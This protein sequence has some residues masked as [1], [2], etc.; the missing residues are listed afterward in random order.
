MGPRLPMVLGGL[1]FTL[2]VVLLS[3][4]FVHSNPVYFS[5]VFFGLAFLG[6]GLGLFTTP[7]TSVAVGDAPVEKAA[8]AGGIFKMGSSLGGAFGITIHMTVFGRCWPTAA[9]STPPPR[10]ASGSASSRPWPA[11]RCPSPWSPAASRT[12]RS[13]GA[14]PAGP[15]GTGPAAREPVGRNRCR[16]P[17]GSP[18]RGAAA[19]CGGTW[20]WTATVQVK[21]KH[22]CI[23][24]GIIQ[25]ST[26]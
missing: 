10:P 13:G 11:P 17:P 25:N 2:L 22:N 5:L 14:G 1:S 20:D 16:R 26:L 15:V 12:R 4:T 8:L 23:C 7:A 24:L 9:A 21:M 19:C 18:I 3:C 6:I